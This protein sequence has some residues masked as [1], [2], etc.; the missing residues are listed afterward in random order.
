MACDLIVL[1]LTGDACIDELY[2]CGSG[3]T[4]LNML[5]WLDSDDSDLLSTGKL[6]F[7]V[8]YELFYLKKRLFYCF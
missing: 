7:Y 6:K 4:Y 5:T 8:S 1:V 3:K 2:N